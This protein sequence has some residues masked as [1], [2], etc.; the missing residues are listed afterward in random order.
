M[1]LVQTPLWS[2]SSFF[3]ICNNV[4]DLLIKKARMLLKE[5]YHEAFVVQWQRTQHLQQCFLWSQSVLNQLHVGYAWWHDLWRNIRSVIA[6]ETHQILEQKVNYFSKKRHPK[7]DSHGHKRP[8]N[9][10]P[11]ST[12]VPSTL[13]LWPCDHE[14]MH[15]D[16]LTARLSA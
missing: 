15:C 9:L 3:Q 12:P 7:I 13:S 1:S 2:I 14:T 8:K 6:S 11:F 4:P 16:V 5:Y 10:N